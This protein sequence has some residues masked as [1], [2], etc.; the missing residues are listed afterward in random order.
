MLLLCH[1]TP[2]LSE[3]SLFR[4]RERERE[5]DVKVFWVTTNNLMTITVI[6]TY[7]VNEKLSKTT[8]LINTNILK[9]T[10]KERRREEKTTKNQHILY[11]KNAPSN[12][13]TAGW[14]SLLFGGCFGIHIRTGDYSTS[15]VSAISAFITVNWLL[16]WSYQRYW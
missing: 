6:N 14:L 9:F 16:L 1:D 10:W 12:N 3:S 8:T 2:W 13:T 15:I 11:S 7:Q 4:M 5:R